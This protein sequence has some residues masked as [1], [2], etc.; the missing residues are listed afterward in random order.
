[1]SSE[2]LLIQH[3]YQWCQ[4]IRCPRHDQLHIVFMQLL[5]LNKTLELRKY[6]VIVK[7]PYVLKFLQNKLIRGLQIC[8]IFTDFIFTDAEIEPLSNRKPS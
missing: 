2:C 5:V 1:M 4:D 3:V 6:M 8:S 7:I